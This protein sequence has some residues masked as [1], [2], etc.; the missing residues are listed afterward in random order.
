MKV[1]K[2]VLIWILALVLILNAIDIHILK[3]QN[4]T[5]QTKLA[6]LTGSSTEIADLARYLFTEDKEKIT[7]FTK[8]VFY[9]IN[10]LNSLNKK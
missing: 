10:Q 2:I 5:T 1:I 4:A 7:G 8:E 6:T 3:K 9:S